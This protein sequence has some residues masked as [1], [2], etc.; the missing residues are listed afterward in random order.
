MTDE[1]KDKLKVF[2]LRDGQSVEKKLLEIHHDF[3]AN[4]HQ[5]GGR[6][7][8]SIAVDLCYHSVIGFKLAG[9]PVNKGWFELLVMG[10]SGTGKSQLLDRMIR[11][12]GLGEIIA[13]EDSKRTGLVYASIQ[14]Q[15]KWV[16]QWG[17]IPTNDRRLLVIDEFSGIPAEEIGKMTQ[18]RSEGRARGGGVNQNYE[19]W[20]RTRLIFLT[21]P[22]NNRGQVELFNYGVQAIDDLFDSSAD[23]R[24]VDLALI[25]RKDE[26]DTTLINKRWDQTELAH[27]YTSDLCRSMVLWAWSREPHHIEWQPGAEDEVYRHAE[28]LGDRYECDIPL[29]EKADLKLKLARISCAVA[30]RLFSTDAEAKKVLVR[31]EHVDFASKFMDR[32]YRKKSMNYFTYAKKYKAANHYS[33]DKRD[34]IKRTFKSF[35][36]E[37][38]NIVNTLLEADMLS[39]AGLGDMVNIEPEDLKKL[40][41]YLVGEQLLRR[42]ARG[43]RKTGAFQ[44]YLQLLGTGKPHHPGDLDP[45]FE[46]GGGEGFP[47]LDSFFDDA[48]PEETPPPHDEIDAPPF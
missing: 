10:D 16:L 41:K 6:F 15:G 31:P 40:W 11:H 44:G 7:D 1:L 19:T 25:A 13:G 18:L 24:R 3:Q 48:E 32:L 20:A 34:H 29:A 35:G 38:D 46:A 36:T 17:K 37:Y 12:Y 4:V 33:D 2:Q 39:K 22:R 27:Q 5:I 28:E 21:N 45:Q 23:L 47:V 26:V 30:A 42:T 8:L 14:L 9:K 43:Y